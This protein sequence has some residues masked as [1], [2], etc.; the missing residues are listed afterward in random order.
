LRGESNFF[1]PL[2]LNKNYELGFRFLI[3]RAKVGQV[4]FLKW[5]RTTG[6]LFFFLSF[7]LFGREL[8]V[9]PRQILPRRVR[10]SPFPIGNLLFIVRSIQICGKKFRS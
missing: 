10:L 1:S 6:Y 7:F 4:S 8:P 5:L 2:H 9:V 3:L